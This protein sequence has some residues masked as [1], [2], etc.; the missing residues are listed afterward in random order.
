VQG[1]AGND[2]F[3]FFT[4]PGGGATFGPGDSADGGPGNDALDIWADTGAILQGGA[5]INIERVVHHTV[6]PA[7]GDFTADISKIGSATNFLLAGDYNGHNV[8]VNNL[9]DAVTIEYGDGGVNLDNLT[10]HHA[11]PIGTDNLTMFDATMVELHTDLDQGLHVNSTDG[12]N[13]IIDVS[14]VNSNVVV[15]GDTP[16]NF[17]TSVPGAYKFDGGI[18]D[19]STDTGGVATTFAAGTHNTFIGGS[20]IDLVRLLGNSGDLVNFANGEDDRVQFEQANQDA[21]QTLQSFGV[22]TNNTYQHVI[23]WSTSNDTINI[24]IPFGGLNNP[25]LDYTD[26]VPVTGVAPGDATLLRDYTNGDLIDLSLTHINFIKTD[27]AVNGTGLT[28]QQG[29][30]ESIGAGTIT[31]NALIHEVVWSYY[32]SAHSQMVLGAVDSQFATPGTIRSA[33]HFDVIGTI[34]MSQTDYNNFTASNLHF[35]APL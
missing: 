8:T 23:N 22:G 10:L 9:V 24:A 18:I 28:A 7:T 1:G 26:N 3:T 27:T 33:D 11:G 12:P 13:T 25:P 15:T 5:I 31:V 32:D 17:G 6:D 2:V 19:A 29:F 34:G 4:T 16:L 14:N 20:G 21:T 30:A 35:V